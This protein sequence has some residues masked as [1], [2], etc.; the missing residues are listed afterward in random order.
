M[1][2]LALDV[3]TPKD[4]SAL[5]GLEALETLSFEVN[6]GGKRPKG[7][8]INDNLQASLAEVGKI[9]NLKNLRVGNGG[10]G[11]GTHP[12][13]FS[14]IPMFP[15][16]TH[17]ESWVVCDDD[18]LTH[19][20]KS[21]SL[22]KLV[23][24][25]PK[26]LGGKNTFSAKGLTALS[27]APKL[28]SIQLNDADDALCEAVAEFP[29]LKELIVGGSVTKAAI[30]RISAKHPDLR[31]ANYRDEFKP[32]LAEPRDNWMQVLPPNK[33]RQVLFSKKSDG[34]VL[35]P[36]ET[37]NTENYLDGLK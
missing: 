15:K 10:A 17:L 22:M 30:G 3:A 21:Q 1:K 33:W 34:F 7:V 6:V 28:S 29:S 35:G 9:K 5:A 20:G 31:I 13:D 32:P 4:L 19:I 2:T 8:T 12:S 14:A 23:I 36:F 26:G 25:F 24:V 11:F 16:L 27:A 37:N 18:A